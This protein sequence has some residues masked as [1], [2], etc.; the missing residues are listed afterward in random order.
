MRSARKP[1]AR[2]TLPGRSAVVDSFMDRYI[3]WREHSGELD[4]AYR[5]W[6]SAVTAADRSSAFAA[7][8]RALDDEEI[9]A[10][11][12]GEIAIHAVRALS[13]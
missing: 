7:F 4:A 10:R 13:A 12:F 9:A 11:R 2:A 6:G 3:T 1:R 5:R 8:S